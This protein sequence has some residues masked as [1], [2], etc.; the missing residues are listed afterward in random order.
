MRCKFLSLIVVNIGILLLFASCGI[1][2]SLKDLPDINAYN[3]NVPVRVQINDSTYHVGNNFLTR[4]QQGLWELYVEGDPLERGLIMGILSQE[5]METQERIFVNKI[6][7]LVSPG[8][9]Q[10]FLRHFLKWYNRKMY[11]H[12]TPEYKTE[13]YGVSR[14]ASQEFNYIAPPYLRALYM[15]G[16]HDIGH[17]LQDLALVGCSSFAA[18]G[19]KTDDGELIIGR[20]F[21]FYAGDEFAKQKIIAFINPEQGHPYM[22]VT[23]GGFTGV[24]SGMNLE[25]L[26]VTINASKSKIPLLA[27]TPISLLSKEILQYAS[28]IEEAIAIAKKRDVFVS[29]TIMVGSAQDG[30]AVLIEVSPKNFSVYEVSNANQLVCSNHFQSDAYANDKRNAKS[31]AESHTLYRFERMNE[32]LKEDEGALTVRDAVALL[33]N[34][35]GKNGVP[36]GFGNEK[37]LN[38]LL[39]HHGIVFKPKQRKVWVSSNPYQMGAFVAYD[40]DDVFA[41]REGNPQSTSLSE[42][43]LLI[44]KDPFLDTQ[45]YTNYEEYRILERTMETVL[46]NDAK[47]SEDFLQQL[48]TKNTAYWKSH[49]LAGRYYFEQKQYH[50]ALAAFKISETKE[51]TTV[52]DQENLAKYIKKAKRKSKR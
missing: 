40:L 11:L 24:A 13:I 36:I 41:N 34:K 39:A 45:A 32:I 51:I 35:E 31:I 10:S 7:D 42:E 33:R 28:N 18:W 2:K 8:T 52:P 43:Y 9:R 49:Y 25:G 20:N 30:K 16:A 5:L 12:V 6:D 48:Q 27:K 15:H 26:T 44:P 14:Y 21:D 19:D 37:A 29:E 22:S 50:K 1:Q 17:A 46:E 4:N 23:W 38:Q 47:V 3:N